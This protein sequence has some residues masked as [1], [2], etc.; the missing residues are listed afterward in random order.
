MRWV[1]ERFCR[2]VATDRPHA[3][4]MCRTAVRPICKML[5]LGI[6]MSIALSTM[7]P[8]VWEE[9]AGLRRAQG[10]RCE[11]HER[12][13]AHDQL[14]PIASRAFNTSQAGRLLPHH[15]HHR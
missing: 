14:T 2:S 11:Q 7:V 15:W 13:A 10:M 5:G 6:G 4:P 9:M 12:C 8:V 1:S 3:P